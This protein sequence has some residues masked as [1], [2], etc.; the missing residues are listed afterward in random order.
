MSGLQ[1]GKMFKAFWFSM[2][3]FGVLMKT[4]AAR[5]ETAFAVIVA[6]IFF[7]IDASL[8]NFLVALALFLM[9][10]CVEA[11]NTAIEMNADKVS[12]ERSDYAR[13]TKD[14]GSFAVFCILLIWGGYVLWVIV[15]KLA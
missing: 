8:V 4:R 13:D 1:L 3:G 10:L 12:P 15:Q 5:Q 9:V 11:I 7:L 6:V 14:L 2:A